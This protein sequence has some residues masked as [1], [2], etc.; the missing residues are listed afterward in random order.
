[1]SSLTL[2]QSLVALLS[3]LS[4]FNNALVFAAPR[5]SLTTSN[6]IIPLTR[7]SP[8][9]TNGTYEQWGLWAKN[10]RELLQTKYGGQKVQKRGSGYN[11]WVDIIFVFH[12][13]FLTSFQQ[14]Y[15]P[16]RGLEFLRLNC[17]WY[18]PSVI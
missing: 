13:H 5:P 10:Q 7:R 3:L 1:M 14:R 12:L 2:P 8:G 11:L 9:P 4:L 16:E 18:T 6:Q 15:K 17:R